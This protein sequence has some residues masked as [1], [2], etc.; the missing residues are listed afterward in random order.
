MLIVYQ[1]ALSSLES[2]KSQQFRH[3]FYDSEPQPGG[4]RDCF[5]S[6]ARARRI[7]WIRFVLESDTGVDFYYG[8]N[9]K[10]RRLSYE[11]VNALIDIDDSKSYIV[12]L[13]RDSKENTYKFITA[14]VLSKSAANKVRTH[15][16]FETNRKSET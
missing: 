12:C 15:P 10:T 8:K 3:S 2:R 9:S 13:R 5:F 16:R 14:Y 1:S 11:R 6:N 4:R 7:G